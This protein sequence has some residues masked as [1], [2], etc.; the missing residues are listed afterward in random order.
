MWKEKITAVEAI[1]CKF[2]SK[3]LTSKNFFVLDLYYSDY[4]LF[5]DV[6]R[7]EGSK[8]TKQLSKEEI[9]KQ[10]LESIII[11]EVVESEELNKKAEELQE[12]GRG[13]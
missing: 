6:E 12:P 10:L 13:D 1:S 11:N 2:G 7:C 9:K 3:E 4:F 5:I 8:K